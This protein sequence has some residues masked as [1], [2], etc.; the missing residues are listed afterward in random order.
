[1]KVQVIAN[2]NVLEHIF[3]AQRSVFSFIPQSGF[4]G[5]EVRK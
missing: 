3:S 5:K 2:K 4:R 1:M